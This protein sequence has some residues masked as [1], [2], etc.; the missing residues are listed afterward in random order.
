MNESILVRNHTNVKWKTVTK[1]FLRYIYFLRKVSNLVRHRKTHQGE[2]KLFTCKICNKNISS[3]SN[4]KQHENIHKNSTNRAS[5]N[6]IIQNCTKHFLYICTLKK[7]LQKDHSEHYKT[8]L[9]FFPGNERNFSVIYKY[10]V[11]KPETFNFIKIKNPFKNKLKLS[12]SKSEVGVTQPPQTLNINSIK[13][14]HDISRIASMIN[15][16]YNGNINNIMNNN[17][18]SNINLGLSL[19]YIEY[20]KSCSE[21]LNPVN[22]L[23]INK[24]NMFGSGG[25]NNVNNLNLNQSLGFINPTLLNPQVGNVNNMNPMLLNMMN[26]YR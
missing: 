17:L 1:S 23:L 16:Q 9:E 20:V 7:H 18:I 19:K 26:L 10:L 11:S 5:F 6:C 24:S 8:I 4:L 13:N 14:L 22:Q 3:I 25:N 21:L 12:K 15:G 2:Q